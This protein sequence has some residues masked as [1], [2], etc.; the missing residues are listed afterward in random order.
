MN[1]NA[2]IQVSVT[3]DV[4][5]RID[6]LATEQGLSTSSYVRTLL[7]RELRK[8]DIPNEAVMNTLFSDYI[9]YRGE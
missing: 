8:G 1:H 5:T 2:T 6:S 3:D 4:K 7:L 9:G